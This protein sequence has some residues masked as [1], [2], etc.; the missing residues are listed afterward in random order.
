MRRAEIIERR[1]SSMFKITITGERTMDG[2]PSVEV[3]VPFLPRVGDHISHDPS[4]ISGSV[5]SAGFWWPEDGGP[6]QIEVRI[7]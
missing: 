6:L 5:K 1:A 4:G 7:K 2:E 3:E